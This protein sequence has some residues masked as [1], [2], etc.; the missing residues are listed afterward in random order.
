LTNRPGLT[1][2]LPASIR[3]GGHS[4]EF[5]RL[6]E[7]RR[8]Y[9]RLLPMALDPEGPWPPDAVARKATV[10]FTDLR[11][12]SA[13]TE[14]YAEDPA[15][16]LGI[17][18][19]H[20]SAVVRAILRCGAIVEKFV[21]DGVFATFGAHGDMPDHYERGLAAALAVVGAN[22]AMNRRY[23]DE[24]GFRLDVGVGV[25]SGKVVTGLVG[26]GERAE[27]A[28]LGDAVN[29][30]ARLVAS[31]RSGEILLAAS[32]YQQ[33]AGKIRGELLGMSPIRGRSGEVEIY[34]LVVIPPELVRLPAPARRLRSADS[35]ARPKERAARKRRT[36]PAA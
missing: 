25:A 29:I 30:A 3:K 2:P 16:L 19:I 10:L 14:S 11:G 5:R 32:T 12:F 21:G 20:L 23:A 33:V 13:L 7:L 6:V 27:L 35:S 17:V 8:L 31:A 15:T 4:A 1:A 22:E 9:E 34:R 26:V 24:W 36:A 28:V 18:N